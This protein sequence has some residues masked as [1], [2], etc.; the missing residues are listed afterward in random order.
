MIF[1]FLP[2]F[3]YHE[4][5]FHLSQSWDRLFFS[6]AQVQYKENYQLFFQNRRCPNCF[7]HNW[8][9]RSPAIVV[10]GCAPSSIIRFESCNFTVYCVFIEKLI[11]D[12]EVSEK[13]CNNGVS[14]RNSGCMF[15]GFHKSCLLFMIY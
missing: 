13:I 7:C 15:W 6:W 14:K 1:V 3:V 11:P 12:V 8:L 10:E 2:Y 9:R 4:A 5:E